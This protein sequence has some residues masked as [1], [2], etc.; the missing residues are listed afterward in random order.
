MSLFLCEPIYVGFNYTIIQSNT[1]KYM[2]VSRV[3]R[4]R[5]KKWASILFSCHPI[6]DLA[7]LLLVLILFPYFKRGDIVHTKTFKY[8]PISEINVSAIIMVN[9]HNT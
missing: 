5:L 6:K 3:N 7:M 1:T 8:I 9:Q 4:H 2:S